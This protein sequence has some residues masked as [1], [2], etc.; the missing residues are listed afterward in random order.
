MGAVDQRPAAGSLR[1]KS[2][3]RD[4][5]RRCDYEYSLRVLQYHYGLFWK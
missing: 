1:G 5:K 4:P 2:A 3:L